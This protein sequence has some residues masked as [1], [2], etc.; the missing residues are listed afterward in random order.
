MQQPMFSWSSCNQYSAQYSFQAT[1]I[2]IVEIMDSGER[3]M[4]PVTMSIINLVTNNYFGQNI[5][6]NPLPKENPENF[7]EKEKNAFNN[8]LYLPKDNFS[9]P[10]VNLELSSAIFF[11][12]S[13][14]C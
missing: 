9:F 1:D 2:T 11:R 12:R 7:G 14:M 6:Q 5:F 4:N 13:Y 8:V 10:E 3:V